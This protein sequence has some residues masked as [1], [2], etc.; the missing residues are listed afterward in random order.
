[1]QSQRKML[2]GDLV[3]QM[4]CRSSARRPRWQGAISWRGVPRGC[5]F[6][7]PSARACIVTNGMGR[8]AEQGLARS[9]DVPVSSTKRV[10]I[11][12]AFA[13][14]GLVDPT[15]RDRR[16]GYPS[17][18]RASATSRTPR[19][20]W[21]ATLQQPDPAL[22]VDAY[23]GHCCAALG[24]NARKWWRVDPARMVARRPFRAVPAR[25]PGSPCC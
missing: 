17:S 11:P 8:L 12:S 15:Q 1:M 2:G 7:D 23:Q 21:T 6:L 25:T 4:L 22:I 9:I 3:F 14:V 19:G 16:R 13:G 5:T 18:P 10:P 24:A 20:S